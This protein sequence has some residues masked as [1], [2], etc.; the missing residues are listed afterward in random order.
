MRSMNFRPILIAGLGLFAAHSAQAQTVYTETFNDPAFNGGSTVIPPNTPFS[1]SDRW[2]STYY[3][4]TANADGWT[5]TGGAY[6]AVNG[7]NTTDGAILLNE[8]GPTFAST[9]LTGLTIGTDY[10]LSFLQWG[11]NE[12]GQEYVGTVAVNG[13][14]LLTYS[15][16][17]G[18][19]GSVLGTTQDVTFEATST[20]ETLVFGQASSSSASPIIDDISVVGVPE[21]ASLAVLGAGLLGLVTLR[22]RRANGK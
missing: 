11:D 19:A 17:D 5:F 22:R 9:T 12:P 18:A 20:S 4:T 14:T 8:N 15:G 3:Y 6:Y 1:S 21:P 7:A 10:V 13:N 2:A 16:V